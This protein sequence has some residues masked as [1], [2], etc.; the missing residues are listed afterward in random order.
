MMRRFAELAVGQTATVT[1]TVTETDV[2]TYAGITGDM[3]PAHMDQAWA[4]RSR[5]GAR[6][7]HG[8]L[9]AGFLSAVMGM[10]LPGPGTIYLQQTLRFLRPVKIGD[11]V[12]ARAEVVELLPEKRR[13]RMKT[14]AE[15]QQ[16]EMVLDGEALVMLSEDNG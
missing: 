1:R 9:T 14:T 4:E 3:N 12:T 10:H 15:N 7:A 6:V 11:T 5:F 13:A 8:M 16:G 2:A